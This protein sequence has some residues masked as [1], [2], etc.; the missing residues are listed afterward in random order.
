MTNDFIEELTP[1]TYDDSGIQIIDTR[2]YLPKDPC[3]FM[4]WH[5][6]MEIL[7]VLSGT[8]QLSLPNDTIT[9]HAGELAITN[10]RQPHAGVAGA[11]GVEFQTLMFDLSN[12]FNKTEVSHNIL[13]NLHN[14]ILVLDN[15]CRDPEIIAIFD[16]II[17][18][19]PSEDAFHALYTQSQLLSLLALLC[20]KHAHSA[21]NTTVPD[22]RMQQILKY[23]DNHVA[24]DL[25]CSTL[26]RKFGYDQSYFCRRFKAVSGLSLTHYVRIIRLEKCVTVLV[27]NPHLRIENVARQCGFND[28][29]YFCKCFRQHYGQTPTQF[30]ESY[31]EHAP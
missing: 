10:P 1:V 23:I 16:S 14:G 19:Y 25:R 12:F 7:R 5:D 28:V 31:F 13:Q 17:Q 27:K 24:E 30:L 6:R 4:Y 21:P 22:R 8:L 15:C 2:R 26:C 18:A 29:S 20:A 3:F 11:E 9:I